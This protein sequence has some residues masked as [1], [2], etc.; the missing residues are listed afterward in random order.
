MRYERITLGK[1]QNPAAEPRMDAYLLDTWEQ[2]PYF[3]NRP[4]VII[5]PGG[6]YVYTSEREAEPV[7]MRFLAAGYHAFVLWYSV[8]PSTRYPTAMTELAQAVQTVREHAEDWKVA[9]N[10]VYVMGMS[11]GGHLAASLGTL[12]DDPVLETA[13]Q[14][15]SGPK[16]WK[17]N[18]MIL[19]YPVLTMGP[20]THE[21]SRDALLGENAAP[22]TVQALSLETRVTPKT[23]PA[24]IWHTE[25]DG[26]VPV[27]NSLMYAT[28]LRKA[29][30]SFELH[31]YQDGPHGISLCDETTSYDERQ[32]IPDAAGWIDLAL[33]WV[34]RQ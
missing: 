16:K 31:I 23:V 24:F 13:F 2:N 1:N 22:E 4:A 17:P 29:G 33:A 9:E 30:V 6:G 15:Q 5:C 25:T 11:A 14:Y 7:A 21:G 12:W 8:T 34:K 28:A 19:C 27:E 26:A 10:K 32:I 20:F 18:G 3:P